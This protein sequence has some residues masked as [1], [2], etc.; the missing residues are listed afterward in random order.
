M[1]ILSVSALPL[2]AIC[3]PITLLF[4]GSGHCG[5]FSDNFDSGSTPA[6]TAVYGNAQVDSSGGVGNS[7]VLKLT[8]AAF[9][10]QGSFII[11]DLDPGLRISSFTA[12]FNVRIGGGTATPG[13]G[14]SFNFATDLPNS[15]FN[16]EGAGSGL[17]ITF[18]AFENGPP[19]DNSEGPEIRI[20]YGGA[21]LTRRKLSN[22]LR[23]DV[24]FVPVTVAYSSSGA[25]TLVYNN[26]VL[27]TNFFV[28]GP[29]GTGA[30]FGFSGRCGG[31]A[32]ETHYIDD[33]TITTTPVSRFY[34]KG[35]VTPSPAAGVSPTTPFSV[36][37]QDFNGAQVDPNTVTMNFNGAAVTPT[38][39]KPGSVTTI[40]FQPPV[41]L[42]TNSINHVAVRFAYVSD[43]APDTLQ[44]DFT[45]IPGPIWG[46]APTSRPYLPVDTDA[47]NGTTPLYRGIAY[48]ALSNHIYVISRTGPN[49]NLT[50]NVLD[51]NTGADLYQLKTNGIGPSGTIMLAL[52]AVA[53][54]GVLYASSISVTNGVT[55]YRWDNDS[56]TTI[57]K[58]VF[59]GVLFPTAPA[60][61]RWGDA[62]GVRGAGANTQII[63]DAGGGFTNSAILTATDSFA[64]NFTTTGYIHTYPGTDAI[65]RSIQFGTNNTYFIKR[66]NTASPPVGGRALQLTRYDTAP[67][68]TVL[69]S[70]PDFY[71]Q[72]GPLTLDFSKNLAAG[73]M[74][75]T[76][77]ASPDRLIVYDISNLAS[78]LQIAQY[79]FPVNHQKNNNFIGQAVFGPDKIFAVDGNNGIIAVPAYPTFL[80]GLS[81]TR[82]D[83]SVVLTWTHSIPEFVLQA[84]G[85]LSPPAWT[86]AGLPVTLVGGQNY[87]TNSTDSDAKFYRL[88]KP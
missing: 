43:P 87:V 82:S 61:S 44:Y 65:G 16:E 40:S 30:R 59:A 3:F 8:P 41:P 31:G 66:R 42:P 83:N 39:T 62:L 29:M 88:S 47:A 64:T 6:G 35:S 54:D 56:S 48:N 36:A 63:L 74:F 21:L 13:D 86:N 68:T 26:I 9:L 34:V 52:M 23:T 12:T 70:V 77:T 51:A 72:V 73:I 15:D 81:I 1:K 75:V 32:N 38:V 80:P 14:M 76:N 67:A 84:T 24:N 19:Y 5:S 50:I 46:L 60:A 55:I 20:K 78:P 49:T 25:L 17:T 53:D 37:L 28:F 69:L 2:A 45:V 4:P 58:V 7:G 33:L 27:Y 71:P 22:Q 10:Q 57:P 18:D 85:T 79:N 11:D